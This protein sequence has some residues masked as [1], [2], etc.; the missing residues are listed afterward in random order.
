MASMLATIQ[1]LERCSGIRT[2]VGVLSSDRAP[3]ATSDG[4]PSPSSVPC[5]RTVTFERVE[6]ITGSPA[7][8]STAS[9]SWSS[10]VFNAPS[11]ISLWEATAMGAGA[12]MP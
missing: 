6:S 4:E 12:E 11:S 7:P 10:I 5:P 2:R 3:S 9:S 8:N 1:P